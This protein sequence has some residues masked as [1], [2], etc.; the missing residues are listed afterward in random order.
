MHASS[1][2]NPQPLRLSQPLVHWM[3]GL[4]AA[5]LLLLAGFT[6]QA[7]PPPAGST[8]NNQASVTYTDSGGVNRTVLSNNV[9][10]TVLQVASL[11]LTA[12]GG[13]LT[14][15]LNGTA[16]SI[17]YFPHTL[18]N[19]GNGTDTFNLTAP[20]PG[21]GGFAMTN[22]QI[23]LDNGSGLPTGPAITATPALLAGGIFKFIVAATLPGSATAG[24][25]N[26]ITVTATSVAT[27]AINAVNTDTTTVVV[28][29]NITLTKA[30]SASSGA[31]GSGPYTY[32]I[33]YNNT[34]N[35]TATAVAIT[36]AIP[37]GMVYVAGSSRW[38]VSGATAL[39]DSGGSTGTAPNTITST[40]TAGSTTLV[41]TL[42]QVI[43]GG[44][45]TLTFQ[46]NVAAAAPAGIRVNT[47][48]TS[49]TSGASTLTATS[50]GSPFNVTA[51]S[52]VTFV[53][54]AA[55][56][57]AAA[58]SVVSFN[59]LLTNTGTATDTFDISIVSNTFPAGTTIQLFNLATGS[60][61]A[62]TN[63]GGVVDTGPVVA[64]GTF[65]VIL[66]ATLPANAPAS[67]TP[68]TVVK[69]ATSVNNNTV[70]AN[71]T[72][73]LN[74][75]TAST[76]DLTNT[77]V[78]PTTGT[79]GAGNGG[80]SGEATA[81]TTNT[82]NP[83]TTTTFT[84]VVRN[85]GNASDNYNLQASTTANFSAITLPA[86]WSVTFKQATGPG[87]AAGPT[88]ASCTSTG[89]TLTN[90]GAIAVGAHAVFCAEVTVPVGA[91]PGTFS[92]FFRSLSPSSAASDIKHDAVIVS[93]TRSLSL[94]PNGTNQ[95]VPGGT[96]V[97][98]H[99]LT[100]TGNALEGGGG[101]STVTFALANNQAGFT[102]TVHYDANGNGVIDAGENPITTVAGGIPGGLAPGAS[103]ALLVRVNA[104]AGA[105]AGQ[106]NITT[107]SATTTNGTYTST[108]PTVVTATDT[109]TI[110]SGNLQLLKEQALDANCDGLPDGAYVQTGISALPNGC[111]LYRI[112]VT[113]AGGANATNVVIT[114]ATPT[115]TKISTLA[116]AVAPA[117]MTGGVSPA[118]TTTGTVTTGAFTL[119][120]G[121]S[122]TVTFGVRID[123]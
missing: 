44:S 120:P 78:S 91:T 2:L 5:L 76:V 13:G 16:G 72:D 31:P 87:I 111:V 110:V 68:V 19:T 115:F 61:L 39:S 17:V 69:R 57:T 104:A 46:V 90:T 56:A 15:A 14:G 25:T 29:A 48:T 9:V 34:G 82:T 43:A 23:F 70:F 102:A 33:N 106:V 3:V 79:L 100:N 74:A 50:N 45:G 99:T 55:V 119:T 95:T 1:T 42:N 108:V 58:G 54:P 20:S 92:L 7:A 60:L 117:T 10:T 105:V 47:A 98:P 28:G 71:A 37:A 51:S 109:T 22:V 32:T 101:F 40:Y 103:M 64:G 85:I 11:T 94:T 41:Y 73:T 30:V 12:N 36:D 97:Y 49:Y 116:T 112:T 84:L 122:G 59:N 121:Q 75:V 26:A 52:A 63:G 67:S 6:A 83:G 96:V 4:F 113:N 86:G 18:T 80:P 123:N 93:A 38:S 88:N 35:S 24:Q 62:D 27:P 8:I 114:D 21:T 77:Q 53:G 65:T 66:R 89:A 81:Q 118:P 107:L